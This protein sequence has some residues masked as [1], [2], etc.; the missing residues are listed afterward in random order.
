[1]ISF[2]Y[3]FPNTIVCAKGMGLSI[4]G[5]A[6]TFVAMDGFGSSSLFAGA[7]TGALCAIATAVQTDNNVINLDFTEVNFHPTWG[8]VFPGM[9]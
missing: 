5:V 3:C 6:S 7:A 4:G 8:F 9:T 2:E 1:M